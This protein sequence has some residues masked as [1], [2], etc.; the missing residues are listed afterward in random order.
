M[1]SISNGVTWSIESQICVD[2]KPVDMHQCTTVITITCKFLSHIYKKL[3][4]FL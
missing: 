2:V 4:N 1:S 3:G